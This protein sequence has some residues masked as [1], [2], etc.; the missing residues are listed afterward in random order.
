ME[1]PT[2]NRTIRSPIS[3]RDLPRLLVL[4]I[5][6]VIR[7]GVDEWAEYGDRKRYSIARIESFTHATSGFVE[8]SIDERLSRVIGS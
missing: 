8:T 5:V 3:H 1:L 2:E 6:Y 4:A 7:F